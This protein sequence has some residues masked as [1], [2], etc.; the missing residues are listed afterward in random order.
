MSTYKLFISYLLFNLLLIKLDHF[1]SE[2][3][4]LHSSTEI[5]MVSEL[6]IQD[7]TTN[8]LDLFRK[9]VKNQEEKSL[10]T[11]SFA[12]NHYFTE[13]H[14]DIKYILFCVWFYY[15]SYFFFLLFIIN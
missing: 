15:S 12:L 6:L 11:S 9:E 2:F 1:K 14:G 13:Y 5:S 4:R 3:D 7:D 10:H 8:Y